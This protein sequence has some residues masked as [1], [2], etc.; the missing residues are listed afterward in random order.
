ME[1]DT[2]LALA[3]K[4]GFVLYGVAYKDKPDDTRDFLG[5][6]GNPFA[7]VVT[8]ANGMGGIDWGVTAPPETFVVDGKGVI[9]FKYV[10]PMDADVVARQLMPAIK[11][12]AQ[13]R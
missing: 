3:K 9:R 12:A 1:N 8:D 13:V 11:A 7:G 10:G 6:A 2:L 5:E 4:Q